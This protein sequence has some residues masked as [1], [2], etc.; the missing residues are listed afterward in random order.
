MPIIEVFLMVPQLGKFLKDAI[1][2]KSR[3]L[4][5]MV[6]LSHECRTIIQTWTISRKLSDLESFTLRCTIVYKP[7]KISL[8]LADRSVKLPIG[9]LE[10]IPVKIGDFEVLTDFIV[11]EM[12]EEL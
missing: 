6:V 3:E 7:T 10:D 2:N 1:L 11:L 8:V 12:D 5:G 4:Q 9:L